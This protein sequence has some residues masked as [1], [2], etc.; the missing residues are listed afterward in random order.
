MIFRHAGKSGAK[1]FDGV[2]VTAI[3]FASTPTVSL[4]TDD[5]SSKR[6]ISATYERKSDGVVGKINFDYMVDASGRA[7]IL[8]SKYLKS[9]TYSKAL[10]N[11]A[12][13]GYWTGAGRYG[14]GTK[15]ESSPFFEALTGRPLQFSL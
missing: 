10:K 9:R 5:M 8:G 11:I 14:I 1:I 15:R 7:G 2:K 3:E 6:P 13:W 4:Q 12:Y